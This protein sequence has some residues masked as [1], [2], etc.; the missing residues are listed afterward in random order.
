MEENNQR[1]LSPR[2]WGRLRLYALIHVNWRQD[3]NQQTIDP[4][5]RIAFIQARWHADIVDNCRKG[6]L[7]EITRR[8]HSAGNVE[9]YSVPGSFDIPLLAR[10]LALLG[11]FDA[12]VASGFIVDG[13]I[14]RHDFVAATVID[15]LMRVQ[16]ETDVPVISAVLTP[17]QFQEQDPHERFFADH[18][19]IKG[20]EAAD[21]CL[22]IIATLAGLHTGACG[23]SNTTAGAGQ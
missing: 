13:G 14:Y 22:T 16:F 3:M 19:I 4:D 7:A 2:G 11:R 18:F 20:T 1:I 6:F 8:G 21:A 5:I 12:I 17:H 10:K 9:I 23:T 15:A